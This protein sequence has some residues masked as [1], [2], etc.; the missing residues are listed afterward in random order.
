MIAESEEFH[1]DTIQE[2]ERHILELRALVRFATLTVLNAC[3]I[4]G[5]VEMPVWPLQE[6]TIG[7]IFDGTENGHPSSLGPTAKAFALTLE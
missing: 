1:C 5:G 7:M 6:T 2:V 4:L 3:T